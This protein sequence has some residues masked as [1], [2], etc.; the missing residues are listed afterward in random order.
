MDDVHLENHIVVHEVREGI[1]VGDDASN[2]RC[3]QKNVFGFLFGKELLHGIL[4]RQVQF[5]M[6]SCDD[7]VVAL[8]LK[9]Y[10]TILQELAAKLTNVEE[11]LIEILKNRNLINLN[12]NIS[13]LLDHLVL[14]II[15]E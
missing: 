15:R 3:R 1:L 7:I 13:L 2:F 4:P 10:D 9:S 14:H 11:I 12:V 6:G 5:L 8:V